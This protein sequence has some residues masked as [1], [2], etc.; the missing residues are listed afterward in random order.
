[1]SEVVTKRSSVFFHEKN[2]LPARG[3]TNPSDVTDCAG[4][5]GIV[6]SCVCVFVCL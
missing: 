6:Y 2:Q 5:T 4:D 1:M 3:V